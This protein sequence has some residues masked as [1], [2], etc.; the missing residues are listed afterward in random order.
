MVFDLTDQQSFEDIKKFWLG[1]VDQ[2]AEKDA[3]MILVGNKS[4]LVDNRR[5]SNEEVTTFCKERKIAF[6]ECS[7]KE[8]DKIKDIF[9]EI[10]RTLMKREELKITSAGNNRKGKGL[11]ENK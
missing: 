1:E 10:A 7:A 2:Y 11:A 5:V 8:D 3:M 6:I 9:C 4:D